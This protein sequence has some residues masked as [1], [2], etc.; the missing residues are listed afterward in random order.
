MAREI[1]LPWSPGADKG[2]EDGWDKV[3]MVK[4]GEFY[5]KK[6]FNEDEAEAARIPS[7]QL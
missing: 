3:K 1:G 6:K 2:Q 5:E 7:F 4:S